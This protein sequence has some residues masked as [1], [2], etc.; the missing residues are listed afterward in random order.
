[1]EKILA[2]NNHFTDTKL[3]LIDTDSGIVVE[4]ATREGHAI[5]GE[6]RWETTRFRL[7]NQEGARKN[8]QGMIDSFR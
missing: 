4:I 7:K 2:V 8:P 3:R 6:C 5:A 1:M